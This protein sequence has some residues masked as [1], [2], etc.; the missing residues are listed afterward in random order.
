MGGSQLCSE[1]CCIHFL[2]Q[3]LE[4]LTTQHGIP[5]TIHTSMSYR[6]SGSSINNKG[7]PMLCTVLALAVGHQR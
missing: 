1:P 5:H 2:L 6:C 7:M 3:N 4:L